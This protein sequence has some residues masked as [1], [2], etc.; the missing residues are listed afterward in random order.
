[1]TTDAIRMTI[2]TNLAGIACPPPRPPFQSR[3]VTFLRRHIRLIAILYWIVI[4]IGTHIPA[5]RV[6]DLPASDKTIHLLMFAGLGT[7]LYL[8]LYLSNPARRFILLPILVIG[9]TYAVLDEVTQ[10]FFR[11]YCD[12]RDMLADIAGLCLALGVCALIF[13]RRRTAT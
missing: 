5:E 6:P 13:R 9:C 4:F 12:G 7:V 2:A 1:M 11:R 3:I 10:P 8:A